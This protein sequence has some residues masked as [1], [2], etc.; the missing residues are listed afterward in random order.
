MKNHLAI[1]VLLGI[2]LFT[3]AG[4]VYKCNQNGATVYQSKPCP[5]KTADADF[6][7]ENRVQIKSNQA[8]PQPAKNGTTNEIPDT[9]DGKKKSL[10]IAQEAYRMTKDR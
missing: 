7:R 9:M 6:Q 1:A 4:N 8:Y 3:H 10:A 2:P 5:G